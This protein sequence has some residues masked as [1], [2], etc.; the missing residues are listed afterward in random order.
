[1]DPAKL[2]K[3]LYVRNLQT[4]KVRTL[5]IFGIVSWLLVLWGFSGARAVDPFYK[6]FVAPI[7]ATLTN[8]HL[9]SFSLNLWYK[10]F[11]LHQHLRK[12][13][14]YWRAGYIKKTDT[15]VSFRQPSVD[16]F[17]PICGEDLEILRRIRGNTL[18]VFDTRTE[19]YTY[20]M[21]QPQTATSTKNWLNALA[22]PTSSGQTK[23]R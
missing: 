18:R 16:I 20:L 14:E 21:M 6:W 13:G 22:S 8:Y 1:M 19:K 11:D 12:I 5:Y 2:D 15:V 7:L 17:L 4:W 10:Q 9:I 23:A 3:Y